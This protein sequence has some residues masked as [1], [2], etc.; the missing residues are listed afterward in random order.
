[1]PSTNPW[2]IPVALHSNQSAMILLHTRRSP[3]L[4]KLTP[5]PGKWVENPRSG[6]IKVR[7]GGVCYGRFIKRA[8][9]AKKEHVSP[10]GF[11]PPTFGSGIRRAAVAP[12]A[13]DLPTVGLE[14]TTTR[15]RVLRSTN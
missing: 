10:E 14:P 3:F 2:R 9:C 6:R 12:W 13:P 7:G 8:G 5:R 4:I 1:M 15:L 11:E